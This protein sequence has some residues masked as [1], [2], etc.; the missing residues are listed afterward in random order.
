MSKATELLVRLKPLVAQV[1]QLEGDDITKRADELTEVLSA[2]SV[3][4]RDGE[5]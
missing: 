4:L 1:D 3:E 5:L 2:L